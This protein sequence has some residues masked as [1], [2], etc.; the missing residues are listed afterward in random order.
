MNKQKLPKGWKE[1]KLIDVSE[2]ISAGGTPRRN[3]KEYW[4]NGTIPWLKISDMKEIY[5][6][7]IDE[8]ITEAGL[9]NSSTKLFPKGTLVYSIFAT[10]GAIGILEID[11]TT[12]QAIVGIIPK[13]EI[14][15]TK[16]LYYCLK[17][18]RNKILE[19]KSHATQDNLN[20]GI[21]RNHIIP[22][23]TLPIQKKI[24]SLLEKAE[25]SKE[26]RKEADDLTKEFLKS[27]F[28]EMFGDKDKFEEVKL[29]E[30]TEIVSGSTPKTSKEE[31]WN[32]DINWIAPAELIDGENY[33]Y[34]E[35]K[36]KITNEGLKS[37]SSRLFPKGTVMLST[38]API[39]KVAIAGKEMCSNQGFKNLIPSEEINPVYLYFWFLLKKQYLNSLGRGATFKEISKTIVSNIKIPLPPIEL[40]NKFA[41]IVKKVE[42]MKE[43]QKHSKNQINNLFNALMQKAFKGEIKC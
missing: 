21:L 29:G 12:N 11:A 8:K 2:S 32:G 9:K 23:P 10:L 35:T 7:K 37:C 3:I 27:V 33:Y 6:S 16:Y 24:V 30:V 5:I 19:K 43:Q 26:L 42:A 39:G 20:L 38:R 4:E 36:K 41:S 1:Y 13:K 31:Y 17:S 15:D 28:L 18:E 14:I 25:K 34:F 40:Q 22:L